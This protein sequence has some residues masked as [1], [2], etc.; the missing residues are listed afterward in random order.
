MWEGTANIL[1]LELL[2]LINKYEAHTLFIKMLR[3]K[4]TDGMEKRI[5]GMEDRLLRFAGLEE[6]EKELEAKS[7]MKDMA[8]LFEDVIYEQ[9]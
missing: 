1:A 2:R 3:E 9:L 5:D 7:L 8:I 4:S 6:T